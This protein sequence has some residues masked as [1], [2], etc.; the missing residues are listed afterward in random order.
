MRRFFVYPPLEPGRRCH[1]DETESTHIKKVLRLQ[2]G[3]TIGLFDGQGQEYT[4]RIEA[5]SGPKVTV[6]IVDAQ[7]CRTESPLRLTVAQAWL[8]NKKMD[9]QIRQLTE[10]GV[11]RWVPFTAD[12][13]VPRPENNRL[14]KQLERW[15]TIA[16]ESLKQCERG[17]LPE[18]GPPT[19][20][21]NILEEEKTRHHINIICAD[22]TAPSPTSLPEAPAED[23]RTVLVIIGPEG[24]FSP[25]EIARA[26]E[27][28]FFPIRL[29]PRILKADTAAIAAVTLIQH[30]FGDM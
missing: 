14:E 16:R 25:A 23:K 5:V 2:A 18:I 9:T 1:L 27:K 6:I 28:H 30:R 17:V 4:G 29:G 10:M 8:K 3:N 22:K 20:F 12:R 21:E 15:K 24:G 26:K 13:S 11:N 7:P 19:H